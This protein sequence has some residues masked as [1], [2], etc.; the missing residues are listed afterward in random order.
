LH[1]ANDLDLPAIERKIIGQALQNLPATLLRSSSMDWSRRIPVLV[2][3]SAPRE[4]WDV[5]E[6]SVG[7]DVTV[8]L[9]ST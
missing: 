3:G 4:D 5:R 6:R 2:T 7:G 1:S 8:G 9:S